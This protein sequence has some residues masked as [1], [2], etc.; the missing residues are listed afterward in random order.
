MKKRKLGALLLVAAIAIG[1]S[2]CYVSGPRGYPPPP[3]HH[4]HHDGYYG[5]GY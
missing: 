2:S 1:F 4:H 3:R 5:G